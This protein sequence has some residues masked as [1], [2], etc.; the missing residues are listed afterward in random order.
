LHERRGVEDTLPSANEGN[1][2][3]TPR[4]ECD[5][6]VLSGEDECA[7]RAWPELRTHV[8]ARIF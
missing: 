1:D 7:A 8:V 2:S 5:D 6:R 4:R 3:D